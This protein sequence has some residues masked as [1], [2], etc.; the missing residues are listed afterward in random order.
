MNVQLE[1]WPDT[2]FLSDDELIAGLNS[3]GLSIDF[4][5]TVRQYRSGHP[6][7]VAYSVVDGSGRTCYGFRYGFR[8]EQYIS[9]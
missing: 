7:G 9:F 1:E 5:K 8:G 6:D 4:T 3:R 2:V